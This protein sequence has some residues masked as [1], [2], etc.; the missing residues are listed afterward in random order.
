MKARELYRRCRLLSSL[1]DGQRRGEIT[2]VAAIS[3][4]IAIS[5]ISGCKKAPPPPDPAKAPWLDPKAQIEAL[6]NGDFRIRGM[7]AYNLGNLGAQAA[8]ALPELEQLAKD[9]PNP[10]VRENARVAAEKVQS[11]TGKQSP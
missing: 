6:K 5:A 9:D 2:R 4:L 1:N 3:L 11:A 7:A 8:D 10:K